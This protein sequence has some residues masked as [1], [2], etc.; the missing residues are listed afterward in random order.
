[1]DELDASFPSALRYLLRRMNVDR[2]LPPFLD[3]Q[4]VRTLAYSLY[5][6]R[7][8]VMEPDAQDLKYYAEQMGLAGSSTA[9]WR[10][11][12]T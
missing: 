7:N 10:V 5:R 1:M 4:H 9:T 6:Y 12:P 8:K 3:A 2:D 11:K